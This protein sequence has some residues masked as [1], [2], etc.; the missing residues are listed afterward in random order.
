MAFLDIILGLLLLWGLYKGLKNGLLI[1]IASIIAL[2][3]G[4]YGA[5][6]FSYISADYLSARWDLDEK[7]INLISFLIT[8]ILIVLAVNLIAKLLTKVVDVVMLGLLN[9]IA[10]G[11]FGAL[12]VAVILGAFLVFFDRVNAR[13]DF[14]DEDTKSESVLYQPLRD[15]GAFVFSKVFRP[16]TEGDDK[17]ETLYFTVFHEILPEST[18]TMGL[19]S[20]S[21][22]MEP[23]A[24]SK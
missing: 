9:K 19:V 18:T 12:K 4:L 21:T 16:E 24:P 11:F 2:I 8:F 17:P 14:L 3:A 20:E 1:E 6:H 7:Y 13:F 10:G 5:F 22:Y 15:I 23:Y